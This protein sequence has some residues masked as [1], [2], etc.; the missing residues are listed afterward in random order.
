MLSDLM[1]G[2]GTIFFVLDL[3]LSCCISCELRSVRQTIE[4]LPEYLQLCL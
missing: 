3:A 4:G 2:R 1:L